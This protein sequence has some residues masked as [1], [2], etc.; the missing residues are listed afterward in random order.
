MQCIIFVE[1]RDRFKALKTFRY[2]S[3]K[4][5]TLVIDLNCF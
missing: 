2:L 5:F 3:F 4:Y 1:N